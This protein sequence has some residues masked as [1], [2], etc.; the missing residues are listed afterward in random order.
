MLHRSNN[1]KKYN[2]SSSLADVIA[3][4]PLSH[5]R[6]YDTFFLS[7][8]PCSHPPEAENPDPS[9]LHSTRHPA[10]FTRSKSLTTQQ[11]LYLAYGVNTDIEQEYADDASLLSDLYYDYVSH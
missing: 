7:R 5:L 11:Q 2:V 4:E 1:K 9:V 6:M 8:W 3:G 10:D